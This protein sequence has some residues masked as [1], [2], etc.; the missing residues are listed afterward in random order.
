M[1]QIPL[2]Q[3]ESVLR[4]PSLASLEVRLAFALHRTREI[5][6]LVVG[7]LKQKTWHDVHGLTFLIE[8]RC[9]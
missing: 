3:K 6:R 4:H 1:K 7:P 5:H 8:T 2:L 9:D